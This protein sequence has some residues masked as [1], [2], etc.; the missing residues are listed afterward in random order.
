MIISTFYLPETTVNVRDQQV[1]SRSISAGHRNCSVMTGTVRYWV[2]IIASSQVGVL[3]RARTPGTA[4]PNRGCSRDSETP[5]VM[6][7]DPAE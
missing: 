3:C 7:A 2:L 1:P 6:H 5:Y 4:E